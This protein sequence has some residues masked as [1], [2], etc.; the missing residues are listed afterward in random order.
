M[1]AVSLPLAPK[2]SWGKTS[3]QDRW[4]IQ[5][6][7]VFTGLS[8][9]VVYATWAAF[10]G[11]HFEYGPYLSPFYS[12]VLF[13][14]SSHALFGPF[15]SW[16]PRSLAS[17]ALLILAIPVG[18]RMSCYY[19]RGAY[20]KAFWADPSNCAV[21]EPRNNYIGESNWP[22]KIMNI[23]RYFLYLAIIFIFILTYDALY[24]MWFKNPTTGEK[25]FGIGIG[26]LLLVANV[27]LL[28]GYTFGCHSLRHLIGGN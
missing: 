27:I 7:L 6:L 3:R 5:P 25:E 2:R 28:G 15:P 4:W 12:P 14:D 16:W 19:Y 8:I 9:F 1:P 24:A 17:P 20:Y 10:Q 13:G 18:F 22:L 23:H 11:E 21:G 26:T